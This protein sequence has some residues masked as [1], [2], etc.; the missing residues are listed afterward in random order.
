MK[1]YSRSGIDTLP[2]Y[3]V[4]TNVGILAK[5][6]LFKLLLLLK[7]G[8]QGQ[9]LD[10]LPDTLKVDMGTPEYK[11]IMLQDDRYWPSART[12]AIRAFMRS[13][14]GQTDSI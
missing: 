8:P 13:A 10:N 4:K 12:R 7:E 5:Y 6:K 9:R 14:S 2:S 11:L 1:Q 3:V